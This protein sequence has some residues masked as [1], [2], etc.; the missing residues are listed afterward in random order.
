[1]E[2]ENPL[3]QLGYFLIH[4]IH[5]D[6]MTNLP[7]LLLGCGDQILPFPPHL[8]GCPPH[9]R[10]VF[11]QILTNQ[12]PDLLLFQICRSVRCFAREYVPMNGE[13]VQEEDILALCPV[14]FPPLNLFIIYFLG[15]VADETI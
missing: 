3:A 2:L 4:T 15:T 8:C 7:H 12:P 9:E 14:G 1:M 10:V 5:M 13:L 6:L 11:I